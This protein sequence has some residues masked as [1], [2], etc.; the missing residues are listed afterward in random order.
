MTGN[1]SIGA[2]V[3]IIGAIFGIIITPL[4]FMM[5]Y[6]PLIAAEEALGGSAFGCAVVVVYIFPFISDIGVI[7]GVMYA[8]SAIGFISGDKKSFTI[9]IVA[10][11]LA[12]QS[13]FWPII[14]LLVTGL[15]PLFA[16]IFLPNLVIFFLLMGAV[17]RLPFKTTLLALL[18][19]MA[20][21]LAFMN[22]V[23]S[24]NR[25]VVL[26]TEPIVSLFVA[27]QRLNWA[28]SIGWG[29]VTVGIAL[30]PKEW[31]RKLGL[32][33]GILQ[34]AVGYAS[35]VFS[36]FGGGFSMFLLSPMISTLLVVLLISPKVW[37]KLVG[38][39]EEESI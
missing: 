12:L 11:V 10:N 4:F 18:T 25:L 35:G 21:V 23:A 19:G 39:R 7:A 36:P 16:F 27:S 1:R 28:A 13:S 31:V 37:E 32:G 38:K 9:A 26:N 5:L 29:I 20:W 33:A 6:E 22:G 8:L 2:I 34:V 15:T 3:S 17:R 14:P 30:N 24:T